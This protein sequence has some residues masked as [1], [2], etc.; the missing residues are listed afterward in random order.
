MYQS[1]EYARFF[2]ENK[3]HYDGVISYLDPEPSDYILEIGCARGFL[4][5][6]IQQISPATFGVDMNEEAISQG[7]TNGLSVMAAEKLDFADKSFD[8]IYSFHTIEHIPDTELA[9]KEIERVLKPG[10]KLLLVYPAEVIR[11]L[12]ALR[13]AWTLYHNFSKARDIHVHL[14]TPSSMKELADGTNMNYVQSK[15]AFLNI[16]QFFTLFQKEGE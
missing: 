9:F 7:V 3:R 2:K 15:F 1:K 14:F 4:T 11:G 16:P 12:A 5:K 10:G 8:K 13:S 6:N